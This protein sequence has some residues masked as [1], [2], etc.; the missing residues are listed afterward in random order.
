MVMPIEFA[1]F[2]DSDRYYILAHSTYKENK[3]QTTARNNNWQE[4]KVIVT[5]V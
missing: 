3:K 4:K 5:V 1:N 2:L